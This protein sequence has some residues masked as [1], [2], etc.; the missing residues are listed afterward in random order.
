M[1]GNRAG[2][3]SEG[4]RRE[5]RRERP[6]GG[7]G[8]VAEEVRRALDRLEKA[9]EGLAATAG[10]AIAGRAASFIDEVAD[11]LER[12]LGRNA[13][14]KRRRR[15]RAERHWTFDRPSAKR[16]S[17]DRQRAKLAGVCAGIAHYYGMEPWVVRCMAVTGLI[18]LPSIVFPAYW[19]LFFVMNHSGGG[20]RRNR[21]RARPTN[22]GA[23]RASE[24]PELG[25][26][27]S[28][29][30]SLRNVQADLMQA[31]LRL[32]RM[33]FLVTSGQYDLHKEFNELDG[34]RAGN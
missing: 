11:R 28:P 32:R 7:E 15:R 24:A 27:F 17:R 25:A 6:N 4:R 23:D 26:R 34:R 20:E 13:S 16:L 9:V 14:R 1:S 8:G 18:F 10:D 22:G 30:R 21:H 31:E 2:Q 19:I 33:E 3:G 5:H 12:D 29:R